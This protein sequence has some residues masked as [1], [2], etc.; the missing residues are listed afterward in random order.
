MGK[1][2]INKFASEIVDLEKRLHNYKEDTRELTDLEK[3]WL[4]NALNH[5]N[6]ASHDL[7]RMRR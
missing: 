7:Y 5:I 4:E 3:G 2:E 6:E 1:K